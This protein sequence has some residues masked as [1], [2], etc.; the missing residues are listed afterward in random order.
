MDFGGVE[1][2]PLTFESEERYFGSFVYPLL[3]ETRSELAS[4]LEIMYKAPFSDILSLKESTSGEKMLYD[5]R[6]SCWRNQSSER[7]IDDYHT[8][9]VAGDLLLLVDGKPESLSDLKRVGRKWALSLVKSNEDTSTEF[10]IKASQPIEFQDGMF[11]VFVKNLANPKRIWDSLHMHRNLNIIKEILYSESTVKEKCNICSFGYDDFS[12][13]KLDPQVLLNLNESQREAVMAALCRTQCCHVSSVEQIWGPPG[14]GK[15]M[16]VSV[17]LFFLL[18]MKQRTLTCA[19]TNVAIVQLASRVLSLVRESFKTTTA[20]GDYFYSVGDLLLFGSKEILKVSTDIEEIY[21]EHRVERLAECLGPLTG[22]KHC[23]R[24]MIDL[25]E[26]C[27]PQYYNFI[28]SEF[29][30]EKQ[31]SKENDD[32]RTM[33]EIKSFIE[34]IQERFSSSAPPLRRCILTFC[35]HISRSFIGECNFQNMISLLD[36]LISLESLLFQKNL[37]SE[38]LEDVFNCK[39]LQDEIVKSCLSLL[40]TLQIS[41]K[42]L[43]LPRFSNKYAIIQF[44][45]ERCSVIFCTTSSSYKLHAINME[46]LNIAVIDEAAMLKEAESTIPL[47]LPGVK[48]AILIGDERQLPAVVNSTLCIKCGFGRSL[49]DRL[50][51]LGHAKHLLGVQYRMH[52]SISFFPN[53]MFYQNQ[54]LDAQNV[55]SKSYE[56]RY[57]SGPVFGSYSFINVVGGREEKDDV[58]RSRRNMVEV[59]VVIKI[60]KKLFRAWQASKENLTI[61]V[62]SPYASQVFSIQEKLSGKYEKHDGFSVKVKSVDGFQGGEEDVVIVSTVRSNS[63]GSVGFISCPQRTNVALTRARHCLWILGNEITL[64]N[65]DSIWKELVSDARRRHCFFDADADECLKTTIIATKKELEQLDDLVSGTSVLFKHA[66]WKSVWL[67]PTSVHVSSTLCY[68][69]LFSDDFRRSFGKL[70]GSRLKKQVLNLLLKLSSGWRPKN[71]SIDSCCKNSSQILKQFKVEGLYVV[72]TIDIIKEAQYVQVL[73]VWDVLALDKIPNLTKRLESIFSAYTDA[74]IRRCTEKCLEGTLEV[75]RFWP[76]SQEIIRFRYLS[77]CEN[78]SSGSVNSGDA[79]NYVENSKV[80]E[81]LLLM[82]FY[83]LSHGVVSHLLS[84]KEVDLPMQVT[85]E[86]MDIILSP[87]SSFIIGRS[88]TGKTTILTMKLFQCE[89]KFRI[90]SEGIYEGENSRCRGAK[91]LHQLFVTVSPKLCYTVKQNVSHLTR[92]DVIDSVSSIMNSSAEINLNDTDVISDIPDTFI[93]IPVKSYPLVITFH[94]FLMMLDGTM[95]NSFFERFIEAR[96]GS[97]GNRI[98]LQTFIRLREVTFDRFCSLYWPHFNSSLTKKLDPSRVFTE[99][100]SHIKGG[101]CS[102]GKLSCENYC[103]LAESR[104]STL[105]KEKRQIVY[106]IYKTYEKMKIERREF[107]LG[108]LVNDIHHRLKNGNYEGDKMDM[109]YIDEVQDLSMRQISLFKYICQNV[110]EGFIFAGD[111]AQTIVRGID[112]RFQDIRSLFYKEFLSTPISRTQGKGLV[113]EIFQLKQNFRTHAAVLDLAQSVIEIIYHYFI[114]SIDKLEP[115]ISL[116][117]GEAPVLLESGSDENPIEKIFG[118][119]TTSGEVVGFG[120]DQ[121]ILVRDDAAKTEIC[122]YVGKN[123]LVLTI[124]E[125]KGLEFQDVLLYNFFGT[126]PLKDQWRVLYGYMKKH[127]LQNKELPRSFPTFNEARHSIL[128][129][130]LKQLYVAITRTRQ[131]LWICENKEELSK[132]MFDYWK[133]KGLVQVRELD[134]SVAQ[135]MRVASSP[136][137]WQERGKKFFYENNFVMATVCFER[138]GDTMWEKLAKASGLRASADQ[139]HGTNHEAFVSYVREAAG[140]FE[141]IGKLES[142]A[143]CYCDLGEYERAGKLYL[144]TCGKID[145]AAECFTLSGCYSEAAEAYTKGEQFSNSLS[146]CKKGKLF[147]KGFEYI[148][149]WKK[150]VDVQCK[151]KQQIEEFLESGALYYS[152]QKDPRT[153]MKF[154]RAFCTMESKRVFLRSLGCLD[155]LLLL[156]EEMGHFLEAAELAQSLGDILKGADLLEKAG[157]YKDATDLLLWHVFI[158]SLWGNGNRGWPLK[159]FVEKEELC[160]RVKSLAKM[161][162]EI[163]YNFVC[164]ELN[165]LSDQRSTLTELKNDLDVSQAYKSVRGKVLSIRKIL[166]VHFHLNSS[167]YEWEDELPIDIS[168]QCEDIMFHDRVSA[169]TLIFYWNLWKENVANI[170]LEASQLSPNKPLKHDG[171]IIFT[172]MYFGVRV[173]CVKE[174][175]VYLLLNKDADWI[176]SCGQKGV[177]RDGKLLTIDGGELADAIFSYWKSEL[178]SVGIKVLETLERLLHMSKSNG[179]AFHQSTSLLRIFEVAKILLTCQLLNLTPPSKKKLQDFLEVSTTYF[180]LVFP[181]D[182]RNSVSEDLISLRNTDLSV[183]LLSEI[184]IQ[185]MCIKPLTNLTIGRMMMICISCSLP[186]VLFEEVISYFQK[187]TILKSFLEK[188]WNNGK[189]DIYVTHELKNVLEDTFRPTCDCPSRIS[190]HSTMYLFDRLLFFASLSSE[191]IFTTKSSLVGWLT[192]FD[193]TGTSLSVP[194]KK[195]PDRKTIRFIVRIVKKILFNKDD[196]AAWISRSKIDLSYYHPILALKGVIMLSLCCLQSSDDSEVLL[197]LL[198]GGRNIAQMLPHKFVS[199]ILSRRK[200][201]LLNLNPEVVAEAFL[202]IGDPLLIASTGDVSPKIKGPCAIF[203]DLRKSKEEIMIEL[204]PTNPTLCAQNPSSND[205]CGTSSEAT[206][207][208]NHDDDSPVNVVV[209]NASCGGNS[210][211]VK[212]KK[213]KG[214]SKGKKGKGKSK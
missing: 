202:S 33:L 204:F 14:T 24:S 25:L 160:N 155:D 151:E 68:K 199:H 17:L 123:A 46:P 82:K 1:N 124:L 91:V 40:K 139:M 162:S 211:E 135:A 28:E 182:W 106:T 30:K 83:S 137:E 127:N 164:N 144:D 175:T 78:E 54:I 157:H 90:A 87:K 66:K 195:L 156:E 119:T 207:S 181:L 146:V 77:D 49:F 29:L 60:V 203:V 7:G 205:G 11:V 9:A 64:T 200:G 187:D 147:D 26:N 62:I 107:D 43:A 45:F 58:G 208:D 4:S 35:T 57:L 191:I 173:Q 171:Y 42:G 166:D 209:K 47:Q 130:E 69:V 143:S 81:S 10:R 48:H 18:Q 52:P 100:I 108:D 12:S 189:K 213:G 177:H 133:M 99:I 41:L 120:A 37:V 122:E 92:V 176:K 59:A 201:R 93:N 15:T 88:G 51:S 72:C 167:K 150:H 149:Y 192:S 109:V 174:K 186:S 154:V 141:S 94:R 113:A 129:S 118:D 111:T 114:H 31:L 71:R 148:K 172:F 2:I 126:S 168:K 67:Y 44:C 75:P 153:M 34:F 112:F 39:P 196:T 188:V 13:K 132:P 85:D 70:T 117:S 79:R 125:C 197:D 152:E 76:A 101:E 97:H 103:L 5:V 128:C 110:E 142:A 214:N 22:W 115:E 170:F 27:V 16:T 65:S 20:S 145:A 193:S 163:Y 184:F 185:Y 212:R 96:E 183:N 8:L 136:Q 56:K 105:T 180:D 102:D 131:R 178:L 74:Y 194:K 3:E 61:G 84:G 50:S 36:Y 98:S 159:R 89:Q 206:C 179:S 165:V 73:K 86:Q 63:H 32:K 53:L 95:G 140:I 158:S 190:P 134:D 21:L 121:V 80:S 169:K 19:P 38:D 210:H 104:S 6:V 23:I 198:S 161:D 138:A 116:I 55:L